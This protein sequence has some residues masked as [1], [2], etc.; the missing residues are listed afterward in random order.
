VVKPRIVGAQQLELP[1]YALAI[2]E[3]GQQ[4][5]HISFSNP[6]PVTIIQTPQSGAMPL[7]YVRIT[8]FSTPKGL[9]PPAGA[10]Y[11]MLQVE[12]QMLRWRDDG[13]DPAIGTGMRLEVS[14]EMLYDADLAGIRFIE[15]QPG[16][17]LNVSFYG[18]AV[19]A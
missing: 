17:V 9:T 19:N 5:T 13:T 7:G 11:A 1:A 2:G 4:A 10:R 3:L 12:Q 18:D 16:A 8:D 6:L 14:G 15:D